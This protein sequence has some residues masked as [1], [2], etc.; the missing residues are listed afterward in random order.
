MSEMQLILNDT[1]WKFLVSLEELKEK[2]DKNLFCSSL[3]VND[4]TLKTFQEFLN[5]F[6]VMCVI[7]DAY[8]YPLKDKCRIKMEFSLSEWLALQASF[9]KE[10]DH[11]N[12]K[13]YYHK[14]VQNKLTLVQKAFEQF[15]LYKK[16]IDISVK[17]S[18]VENLKKKINY[19][20]SYRKS[21][22]IEFLNNKQC[23]VFPHRLVFLDGI[24]CVVGESV[25]DK[26]LVY[27]G[28][29]DIKDVLDFDHLYEPNFSQIEIN[30]FICHLRLIN[31]K[32]ERLVL[33]VYS[34][35][36]TDLLPNHHFLGNP[37]ITSNTEGDM[38]WA[39]TIEICDDLFQWLF[40]MKDRVEI[41][42]PGHIRKEFSHFCEMKKENSELKKVS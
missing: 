5:R 42:D 39:A 25:S 40:A 12:F 3:N 38:I 31:G 19:V 35:Y 23:V 6:D 21:I 28:V 10:S 24:L 11:S 16:P 17:L 36:E 30:E 33:K 37:F 34:Q 27:F 22:T 9:H 15:N 29:E 13:Q 1:F 4:E 32:E 18:E 14:I 7:D 41:L 2:K 26:T 20:I 8:I